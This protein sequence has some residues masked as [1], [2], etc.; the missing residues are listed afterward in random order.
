M[1]RPKPAQNPEI[2]KIVDEI[3][4][5]EKELSPYQPKLSLLELRRKTLRDHYRDKQADQFF[6]A[7]GNRFEILLGPKGNEKHINIPKLLKAVGAKVFARIASVTLKALE[8]EC[9]G[10]VVSQVVTIAPTGSRTLK[11][12]EKAKAAE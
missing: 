9:S 2:T 1:A 5:L 11:I 6:T 12:F 7:I 8:A 4:E 3:G 10:D